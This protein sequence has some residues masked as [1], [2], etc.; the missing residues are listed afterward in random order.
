MREF[1]DDGIPKTGFGTWRQWKRRCDKR[2]EMDGACS[3]AGVY[4]NADE[5]DY[6]EAAKWNTFLMAQYGENAKRRTV[7]LD[8]LA[9]RAAHR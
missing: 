6:E 8:A 1:D 4:A 3:Q 7:E 5:Y 2:D 9:E